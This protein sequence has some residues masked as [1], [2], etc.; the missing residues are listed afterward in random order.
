MEK[1]FD[2][3]LYTLFL[4]FIHTHSGSYKEMSQVRLL[5]FRPE[6]FVRSA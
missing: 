5:Q 2:V 1:R 6:L 3:S 4:S